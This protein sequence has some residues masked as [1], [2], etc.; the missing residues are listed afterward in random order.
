MIFT[1]LDTLTIVL[2]LLLV[3]AFF[4]WRRRKS[5][6][7]FSVLPYLRDR[8]RP[9]SRFVYLPRVLEFLALL[10]LAI[11][12]LNPVQLSADRT[13]VNKGLDILLILDLS[14][15]MQEPIDLEG[16]LARRRAGIAGKEVTRLEA[17]KEAMLGFVQKRHGDRIGLIVFSE[18]SYVVAP[19][20]Q[21]IAYLT[22]YL[23]MVDN[24]TLS[25]EGQTAIG[26]GI[27]TAIN[28]A[29]QQKQGSSKSLSHV[30]IVLT[31]GENN[32]GRDVYA[33]IEKASQTGF[34]IYFIGVEVKRA[35]ETPRL[36]AAVRGAGGNYYDVRDAEQLGKA[37]AEINRL[38]K[39]T[40]LTR[41]QV[42]HV[43]RYHP[44]A[45]ASLALLAASVGLRAIPY[46][47]EVS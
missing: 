23:R 15:S 30:M 10:A 43:P 3:F 45:L 21:D 22:N 4:Q 9:A 26:E 42:A 11:A 8:I 25:S 13:I 44:F 38:E 16:A 24:K 36:I 35:A 41:A 1:R 5:Y 46:F 34:K 6:L 2:P 27:L 20:T 40:Y 39:G 32:T 7:T 37:Y 14:W 47:I 17:V 19:M 12:L 28:L 31:D 18:N 29:A 33:A